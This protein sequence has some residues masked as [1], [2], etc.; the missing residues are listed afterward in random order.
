MNKKGKAA[1]SLILVALLVLSAAGTAF[2][3]APSITY[4]GQQEGFYLQPGSEYTATDLFD[5]FKNVMPGD[6]LTEQITFHNEAKDSSFIKLY[7]K[8]QSHDSSQN[9]LSEKVAA[10]SE[11]SQVEKFLSTLSMKVWNGTDKSQKPV[12]D[13]SPDQ[14]DGLK[15]DVFMGNIRSGETVTLTVELSV[16]ADLGNEYA[17]GIGEVDWIF[18]AEGFDESK[19]TVRKVWS[20]GNASH[21]DESVMVNLLRDGEV[22]KSQ[23][24]NAENGWA[25]TFDRLTEGHKWTVEEAKVPSGYTV[26]YQYGDNEV[27]ITNYRNWSPGVKKSVSVEKIWVNNGNVQP[28]NTQ[29][30]LYMGNVPYGSPVTLSDANGWKYEWSGLSRSYSWSVREVGIAEGYTPS[31]AVYADKTVITN[32]FDQKNESYKTLTVE[33]IWRNDDTGSSQKNQAVGTD[34]TDKKNMDAARPDFVKVNLLRDGQIYETV[35]L[36]AENHWSYQWKNLDEKHSWSAVET[37]IPSGYD[38]SYKVGKD[39]ITIINTKKETDKKPISLTV[40]KKW[41]G[42]LPGTSH[43]M[44][45]VWIMLY[46]GETEYASVKL[47]ESN[48]WSHT[49]KNLSADGNWQIIEKNVQKGYTPSYKVKDG[50]ITVTNT[51]DLIQTGQLNWPVPILGAAGLLLL[52]AGFIRMRKKRK[53]KL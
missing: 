12:Y 46:D 28:K 3:I 37:Q 26:S 14:L 39:K 8:A 35:K 25:F 17:D 15:E 9:P 21:A 10:V 44:Q 23:K 27:T 41:E 13:A 5:N 49:W 42:G 11:I 31:Y 18:K 53:E 16:P 51:A 40:H 45:P 47:D 36:R 24:L 22:V 32:T 6:T 2:A 52:T 50:V 29:I 4:K 38:V 19:L 30:Q 1:M 48:H 43:R 34:G 20:D 33:K 7:M